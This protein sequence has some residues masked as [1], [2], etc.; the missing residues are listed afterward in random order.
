[1]TGKI[2]QGQHLMY[3]KEKIANRDTEILAKNEVRIFAKRQN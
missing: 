3:E 1:M 2:N